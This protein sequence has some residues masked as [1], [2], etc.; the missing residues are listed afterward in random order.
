LCWQAWRTGR[1]TRLLA[2]MSGTLGLPFLTIVQ[3]GYMSY[4]AVAALVV[5]VFVANLARVRWKVLA[6]GLV[7]VYVGMSFYVSYMRDRGEIRETV[8]RGRPL[9]ERV[10]QLAD[11]VMTFEWFNDAEPVHLQLVDVR[12]NQNF[13]VG[14]AVTRMVHT[15]DFAYGGTMLDGVLVLIPRV[16]WPDK[17]TGAGSGDLVSQYTGLRFQ[18][19]TSV[20]IGQVMEFYVNFGSAGV[21]AGFFLL[22]ALM[23]WLDRGARRCLDHDDWLRFARWFVVGLSLM[24]TGGSLVD[25][26]GGAAAGLVAV[27]IANQIY[28]RYLRVPPVAL[29]LP[30]PSASAR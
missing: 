29:P 19:D 25:V 11:T 9:T 14:A 2:V 3:S 21:V 10:G 16:I 23:T 7:V 27:L 8:W 6:L 20:G 15:G 24:Q 13:L 4:G 17:P 30:R 5:F 18:A 22:G 1:T 26:V 28:G 12:L